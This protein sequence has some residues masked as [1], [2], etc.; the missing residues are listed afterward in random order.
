M[1]K[2]EDTSDRDLDQIRLMHLAGTIKIVERA[3]NNNV[4]AKQRDFLIT[5]LEKI[6]IGEPKELLQ[7]SANYK[8]H[9][10]INRTPYNRGIGHAFSYDNF[11]SRKSYNIYHLA[12]SLKVN[13]CPYCNRQYT[14]TIIC[15]S[16]NVTRPEFDHFYS[17]ENYPLLALSFYNLIPSC[18]ICNS[19][20]KGS[21]KFSIAK[22][23]H[24][25]IVG[26][27]KDCRF[28]FLATSTNGAI[29]LSDEI[30]I[31]LKIRDGCTDGAKMQANMDA[32][33][34]A[35]IY[36]EHKDVV[37][38]MIRKH[39]ISG[40]KYLKTLTKAFPSMNAT[41]EE[42][43]QLAFGNYYADKDLDKRPLGKLMKDIFHGL[44]FV[45]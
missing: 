44:K 10:T 19:R 15:G 26:F 12:E 36:A 17:Q 14:F 28:N 24:P 20:L 29:G 2:I 39:H 4:P 40:G 33:S 11:L 5:N 42:L 41:P 35:G 16:K 27:G 30:D 23:I 8:R 9:C 3:I 18:Y 25:Y 1:I 32:F 6:L 37:R 21:K 45:K 38:E 7:V 22:N 13:V 34:L 31:S 43:Y